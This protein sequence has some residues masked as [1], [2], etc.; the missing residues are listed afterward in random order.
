MTT[1][2]FMAGME[3]SKMNLLTKLKAIS[4]TFNKN[5]MMDLEAMLKNDPIEPAE[6]ENVTNKPDT[7]TMF[8][9]DTDIKN[10][11]PFD[12]SFFNNKLSNDLRERE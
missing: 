7:L 11:F 5:I 8:E 10:P 12:H 1:Y 9:K 3:K 4:S 6:A 2:I